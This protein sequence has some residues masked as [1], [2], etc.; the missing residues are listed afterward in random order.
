[1]S[2]PLQLSRRRLVLFAVNDNPYVDLPGGGSH[3]T[4]LVY[5]A[6]AGAFWHFDSAVGS[7]A[8]SSPNA[9]AAGRI[10]Q[11]TGPFLSGCVCGVAVQS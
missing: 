6:A 7:S 11:A 4:L 10:A 8:A 9:S 5:S 1:V 3:W 2:E